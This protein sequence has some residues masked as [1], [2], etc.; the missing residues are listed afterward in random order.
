MGG[1][2]LQMCCATRI[3]LAGEQRYQ[4]PEELLLTSYPSAMPFNL[5]RLAELN[6]VTFNSLRDLTFTYKKVSSQ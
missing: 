6:I 1:K 2:G 5:E 4:S 3:G